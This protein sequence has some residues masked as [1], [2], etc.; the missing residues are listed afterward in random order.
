MRQARPSA[1]SLRLVSG[2]L[3]LPTFKDAVNA[4][5]KSEQHYD[6]HYQSDIPKREFCEE[7]ED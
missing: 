4:V 3:A 6:N 2:S 7:F 1:E 5:R